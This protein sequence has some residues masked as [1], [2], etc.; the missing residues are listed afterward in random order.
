MKFGQLIECSMRNIL[1]E[2]SYAQYWREASPWHFYKNIKLSI[3]AD[4]QWEMS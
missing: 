3:S 1:L 2:K 4:Q